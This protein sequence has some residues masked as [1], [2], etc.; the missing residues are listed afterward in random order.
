VLVSSH[1][2]PEMA[3]TAAELV[4]I[5]RG[6]LI[7]QTSTTDF[8]ESASRSSVRVDSPRLD[9]LTAALRRATIEVAPSGDGALLVT[10]TAMARVGAVAAEA[11]LP[12]SELSLHRGSLEDA[13]MHITGHEVEYTAGGSAGG[14]DRS[15]ALAAARR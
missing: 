13:F 11:G 8:V 9:D 1:L 5:G 2:L 15:A 6:R 14:P 7:A 4:V 10:G 12:L 3:L